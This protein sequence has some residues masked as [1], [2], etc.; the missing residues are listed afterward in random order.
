MSLLCF[1]VSP[2]PP[3]TPC[4]E[5]ADSDLTLDDSPEGRDAGATIR[6]AS[7]MNIALQETG[8]I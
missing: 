6:L 4:R 5:R 8:L 2:P 3:R 1:V 7:H